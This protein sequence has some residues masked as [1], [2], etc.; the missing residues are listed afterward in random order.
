MA[1]SVC[2]SPTL[3][4]CNDEHLLTRYCIPF[5]LTLN[6]VALLEAIFSEPCQIH[7]HFPGPITIINTF[8]VCCQEGQGGENK[9]QREFPYA[10]VTDLCRFI[11]YLHS[12]CWE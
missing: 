9:Y 1:S 5:P 10:L 7:V 2:C 6:R 4:L 8:Q 12:K 3:S 11:F